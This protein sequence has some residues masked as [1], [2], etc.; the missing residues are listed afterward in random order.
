MKKQ[1]IFFLIFCLIG[2]M[3]VKEIREM[4]RER[5]RYKIE[6]LPPMNFENV[7]P[8]DLFA[9]MSRSGR[10]VVDG[11]LDAIEVD[12]SG[13]SFVYFAEEPFDSH[14]VLN[15]LKLYFGNFNDVDFLFFSTGLELHIDMNIAR[16]LEKERKEMMKKIGEEIKDFRGNDEEDLV[17][18]ASSFLLNSL[19]YKRGEG[20]GIEGMKEGKG[21][22]NSYSVLFRLML[23]RLGIECDVCTG[24][25]SAKEY[26]AWNRVKFSD[27][28]YKYYDLTLEDRALFK[29]YLGSEKPYHKVAGINYYLTNEEIG[30][31]IKNNF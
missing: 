18:Q 29:S 5:E 15:F 11:V 13:P 16:K 24:F 10:K 4:K 28:T 1:I 8:A 21:N 25:T 17:K 22:C 20:N 7:V 30:S 3:G 9:G 23:S 6:Q 27:G 12:R 14:E 2:G 26:H 31:F 19:S